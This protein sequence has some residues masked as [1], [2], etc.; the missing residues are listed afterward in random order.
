MVK[1]RRQ[2]GIMFGLLKAFFQRCIFI[3]IILVFYVYTLVNVAFYFTL[4][5]ILIYLLSLLFS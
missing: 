4:D 2:E 1:L 5:N 3:H